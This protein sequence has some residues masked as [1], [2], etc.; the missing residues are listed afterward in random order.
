M[1]YYDPFDTLLHIYIEAIRNEYL[2]AVQTPVST[3]AIVDNVKSWLGSILSAEQL[4]AEKISNALSQE[5]T[6][7]F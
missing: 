1:N 7:V 5:L 6:I 3:R 2:N 4:T